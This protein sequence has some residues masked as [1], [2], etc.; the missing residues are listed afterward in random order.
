MFA[1]AAAGLLVRARRPIRARAPPAPATRSRGFVADYAAVLSNPWARIVILRVHRGH[2]RCG[3]FAYVG[4]DL[5]LRFGL[6]FTVVGLIVG[7]FGIGGLIYVAS[8][9]PLVNR[10]GQTGLAIGGGALLGARLS[11][12][13]ARRRPGGS[14][15]SR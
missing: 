13:R 9:Q 14:R 7:T 10:L 3:A 12:P 11:D 1:I 2:H 5:H 6:S 15:R 4:A 8:V